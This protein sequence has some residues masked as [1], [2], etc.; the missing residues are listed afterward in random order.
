MKY[1]QGDLV[2]E[3]MCGETIYLIKLTDI[4]DDRAHGWVIDMISYFDEE[5]EDRLDKVFYTDENGK[6]SE[7]SCSID[8]NECILIERT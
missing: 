3:Y 8:L 5:D 4:V 7:Y 6:E 1:K 2:A